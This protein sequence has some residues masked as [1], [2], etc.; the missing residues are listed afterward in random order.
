MKT[1]TLLRVLIVPLVLLTILT[2]VSAQAKYLTG[3]TL[4]RGA[5]GEFDDWQFDGVLLA[6]DGV[7]HLDP[8]TA[9]AG[10]DPYPPGGYYGHNFYN[11][12]SFLVGEAVSPEV[13]TPFGFE[14]A[15][16][17]WNAE[18]PT[19][20]WIEAHICARLDDRWTRWYS[21]G[22]WAADTSTVERHWVDDPGDDDALVGID[23]LVV[24]NEEASAN[25]FQLKLQLFSED[26]T[27]VPAVRSA[28]VA[29]STSLVESKLPAGDPSFW[30]HTLPVPECSQMVYPDGGTVWCSPTST[31]MVLAYWAGDSGPCEPH[32]RAAVDGVYDWLYAGHGNWPFNAAYAAT[33]GLEGYVA[34][35]SNMAQLEHWIAAG[36]PVVVGFGW[37]EG[38]LTGAPIPSSYGHLAVLVGFDADG[39]PVVND[40]AAA[41]D[42]EVQRTYLREEFE[43]LWLDYSGGV[44]YL[45]YPPDW[46]VP[47]FSP[48][49]DVGDYA[50]LGLESVW[51]QQRSELHGGHVG[52]QSADA[53][54]KVSIG[55]WVT[56][57]DPASAI[58]GDTVRLS[59]GADVSDA[60]YNA[61]RTSP[62]ATYRQLHTPVSLPVVSNLP[63]LPEIAPGSTDYE[64]PW[65]DSL[66][67]SAGAYGD[68]RLK[69]RSVLTLTGGVYHLDDLSVDYKSQVQVTA[70]TEIRIAGRL[71]L[72]YKALIGPANGSGLDAADLIVYVAGDDG[73]PCSVSRAVVVG[74]KGV[75]T[76]SLY[77]PNGTLLLG[78]EVQ[79]RGAF[80]GRDVV[81]GHKTQVWLESGFAD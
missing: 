37:E 32:V 69:G 53:G 22:V 30:N 62:G 68:V 76:V 54:A 23:T 1:Q 15:I 3:F 28:S 70:P 2:P 6:P 31:A 12:G 49:N 20:T 7:M 79:A 75:V 51:M 9:H 11:G 47:G 10:Q 65:G 16:A 44:A 55:H 40:P 18:T 29:A 14:Q 35:F 26:G 63:I 13:E 19:G 25:A 39:N 36:V 57:H 52:V 21:L 71:R 48:S 4:W 74:Q 50:V 60:Y 58:A 80:I 45:I 73:R 8:G 61:L 41:S 64:V 56:F 77:A 34:R 59:S 5:E 66:E 81:V 42:D 17:S 78:P 46:P 27:T 43:P 24:I 33:Q 72:G 38:D 67:L